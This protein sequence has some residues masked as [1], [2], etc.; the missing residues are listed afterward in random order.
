MRIESD[1]KIH[2]GTA[3][4]QQQPTREMRRN[5]NAFFAS[6]A[7]FGV[8]IEILVLPKGEKKAKTFFLVIHFI[9]HFFP[10]LVSV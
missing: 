2:A 7:R 5:E 10:A 4:G 3:K 8:K 1:K 9:A 6:R